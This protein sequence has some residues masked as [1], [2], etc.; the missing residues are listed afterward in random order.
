M[1]HSAIFEQMLGKWQGTCR[2]W[3]EPDKIADESAVAGEFTPLLGGK[4]LR[5]TYTGAMQGKPRHGEELIVFNTIG[6]RFE[7]CWWD[8]FHMS[9]GLLWSE[10]EP[11]EGGLTVRG[12]YDVG[13]GHPK[14]GWKT[15]YQI[16][17]DNLTITAYNLMPG[18]DEAKAVET[19][20][21]RIR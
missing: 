15:V 12:N 16:A 1:S 17:G 7:T 9:T 19:I 13:P 2:T 20:Y 11:S 4:L 10:G 8:N 18:E 21:H 5:H 14:W 6:E 3:F